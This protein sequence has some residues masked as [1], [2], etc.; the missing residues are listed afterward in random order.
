MGTGGCYAVSVGASA[1]LPTGI[2]FH[3]QQDERVQ[4]HALWHSR[5]SYYFLDKSAPC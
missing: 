2:D 4:I 3:V 1:M 5:A